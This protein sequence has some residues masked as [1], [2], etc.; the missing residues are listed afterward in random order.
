MQ[1]SSSRMY[2]NVFEAISPALLTSSSKREFFLYNSST[3]SDHQAYGNMRDHA[4]ASGSQLSTFQT[5]PGSSSRS[6]RGTL[7]LESDSFQESLSLLILGTFANIRIEPDSSSRERVLTNSSLDPSQRLATDVVSG[8][9]LRRR[10][11]SGHGFCVSTDNQQHSSRSGDCQSHIGQFPCEIHKLQIYS[12]AKTSSQVCLQSHTEADRAIIRDAASEDSMPLHKLPRMSKVF[13][14]E[15]K[16]T[17]ADGD[18]QDSAEPGSRISSQHSISLLRGNRWPGIKSQPEFSPVS[19]AQLFAEVKG[20]YAGLVMVEAKCMRIDAQKASQPNDELSTEQWQALVALHRTLLYEHHDF[21]MATQ[22]PSANPVLLGL[23]T[24][25]STPVRIWK[26]GIHAF[27]EVLRHRRPHSQEYMLAFIYLAYQMMSLLLETVPGFTDTWIECLGD[28]ARYRMAIEED[29]EIHTVWG[30]VAG[31]WYAKAADRRP[32]VGR[33]YHHSGILERP[34]LRKFYLYG[35]ALTSIFPFLNAKESLSTLCTPI[36]EDEH[37][38]C[39]GSKSADALVICFHATNFL[40]Q[41]TELGG[42]ACSAA[43]AMLEAQSED[44]IGAFGV[45][46]AVTNIAA[47][48]SFGASNNVYR[49]LYDTARNQDTLSATSS[50]GDSSTLQSASTF[51]FLGNTDPQP[52]AEIVLDFCYHS[53][54]GILRRE[55]REENIPTLLPYVH[56]MLVFVK[57]LHTL[58][59]R[60]S[61]DDSATNTF[62]DILSPGRLDWSALASFLNHIAKFFPISSR[63]ESFASRE[64]FP[65]DG[66]PLP[67]DYMIRGLVWTQWYFSLSWFES[68]EDDDGSRILEDESKRQHRAAR[69]QYLCMLLA[70]ESN[71]LRYDAATR[72]FSEVVP[73]EDDELE[74]ATLALSSISLRSGGDASVGSDY[75][76]VPGTSP[77]RSPSIHAQEAG[78]LNEISFKRNSR[79]QTSASKMRNLSRAESCI[80]IVDSD[81]TSAF[82]SYYAC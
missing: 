51:T 50:R 47:L 59:S 39:K 26:H 14:T 62:N 42:Q 67:E 11:R 77:K 21:L 18:H 38:L 27:L 28:L 53:F 81:E 61:S 10:P 74:Y 35:R 64:I 46:L 7:T 70:A 22:H 9:I 24:K 41:K 49:Q 65:T 6:T 37:A 45:P 63:T 15:E 16:S 13:T 60:L 66:I 52:Q 73:P 2:G 48:L 30:G 34:S 33:L 36:V 29:R 5:P 79:K 44:S 58:R 4:V 3:V 32:E 25:H 71:H 69:V 31:R 82:G 54:N 78:Y 76:M 20:I 43:L 56:V 72:L 1:L 75:V 17:S 80:S 12:P 19:Q 68:I 40:S 55:P 57:S 23:A 8:T